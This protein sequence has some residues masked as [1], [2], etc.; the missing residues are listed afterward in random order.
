MVRR[1][2][3]IWLYVQEEVPGITVDRTTPL[4][5]HTAL[6]KAEKASRVVRYAFA[7]KLLAQWTSTAL[8]RLHAEHGR[9]GTN[10]PPFAHSCLDDAADHELVPVNG[11]VKGEMR[12]LG[13]RGGVDARSCAWKAR[14]ESEL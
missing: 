14:G 9:P 10:A 12:S 4:M 13:Q 8:R 11:R 7:C 6:L 5:T 2:N 1:G 3:M